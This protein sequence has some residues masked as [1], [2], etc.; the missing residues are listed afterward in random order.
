VTSWEKGVKKGAKDKDRSF[1]SLN[2][3]AMS[4]PSL[5]QETLDYIVDLLHG[6]P[7]ALKACCLVSKSWV[8]RTRKHLFVRVLFRSADDLEA[9]RATFPDPANSPASYSLAL[10]VC[11][12]AVPGAD[13][14]AGGLIRSFSHIESLHVA[15]EINLDNAEVSLAP[16][17]GISPTLKSLRVYSFFLCPQV[18]DLVRSFPLLED[19]ALTGMNNSLDDDGGPHE[20]QTIIPS[21]SPPLTGCLDLITPSMGYAVR[22]LVDIPNGIHFRKLMLSWFLEEDFRWIMELI[23]RCADT[24]ESLDIGCSLQGMCSGS[25]LGLKLTFALS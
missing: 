3:T 24:L 11:S 7:E 8:S 15:A 1:T 25:A 10:S 19:L 22:R 16:F 6:E 13:T 4:N 14:E 21:T 20:P 23:L 18:F 5:P 17:R 2:K 9:W 12:P